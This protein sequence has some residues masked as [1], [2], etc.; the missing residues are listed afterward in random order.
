MSDARHFVALT[1][2]DEPFA[3]IRRSAS[4][5]ACNPA[6]SNCK[7]LR[8]KS[9]DKPYRLAREAAVCSRLKGIK[10]RRDDGKV[11]SPGRGHSIKSGPPK[12]RRFQKKAGKK[13]SQAEGRYAE[14]KRAWEEMSEEARKMRPELDPELLRPSRR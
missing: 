1:G 12:K 5:L 7:T 11:H 2:R 9:A 3:L 6:R 13:R 4:H 14:G 8:F 10:R